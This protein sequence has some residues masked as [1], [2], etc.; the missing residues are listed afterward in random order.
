MEFG[1][2]SLSIVNFRTGIGEH[3]VYFPTL[4]SIDVRTKLAQ[5]LGT[6]L[7][8]WEIGQGLDYF[9]DLL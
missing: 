8:I 9:Y 7:S 2:N 3:K 4:K 6:G 1:L 5:E